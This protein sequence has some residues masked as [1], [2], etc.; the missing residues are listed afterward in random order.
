MRC[1][2]KTFF[3]PNPDTDLALL[4]MAV[5]VDESNKPRSSWIKAEKRHKD[6]KHARIA[7]KSRR[8]VINKMTFGK[9]R[10]SKG[11]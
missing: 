11:K 3:R 6:E 7:K 8:K 2:D 10:I 9:N 1:V 4:A 5:D